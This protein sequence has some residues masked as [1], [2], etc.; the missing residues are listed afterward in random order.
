MLCRGPET[1][2]TGDGRL[3]RVVT[4]FMESHDLSTYDSTLKA[5]AEQTLP[6]IN[7]NPD[8]VT[9]NGSNKR[10]LAMPGQI[11]KRYE[12]IGGE[13]QWL[14]KPHSSHF[15]AGVALLGL[16]KENV[17]H[18]GDSLHHDVD[19]AHKAGLVSV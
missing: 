9:I 8:L 16:H 14:G 13:V 2:V 15:D 12:S 10:L 11:S 17:I 6:M 5:C 7:C 1:I 3:D 19:G 18:V 4:G